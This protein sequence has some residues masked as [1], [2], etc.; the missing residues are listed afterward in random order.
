[1]PKGLL[2]AAVIVL[3]GAAAAP[4]LA[5]GAP[6]PG[7]PAWDAPSTDGPLREAPAARMP[8]MVEG[9]MDIPGE[10][11]E[12][13][14]RIAHALAAEAMRQR[15]I[16]ARAA[17]SRMMQA[18]FARLRAMDRNEDGE[19]TEREFLAGMIQ[20]FD[21]LDGDGNGAI[22]PLE[23]RRLL[24]GIEDGQNDDERPMR[25]FERRYDG[26]PDIRGFGPGFGPDFCCFDGPGGPGGFP[27]G[28]GGHW[29]GP[30][31]QR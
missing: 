9:L 17:H 25:E 1:M 3:A 23:L 15:A 6:G 18:M 16:G 7:G 27:G 26:G 29:P 14:E 19:I 30:G 10:M 13:Q 22:G 28:P 20:I 5:Q 31:S 8:P 4:A 11:A 2:A 12:M 21:R 24:A